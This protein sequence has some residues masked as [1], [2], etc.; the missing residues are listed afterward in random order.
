M[1]DK[2]IETTG[3]PT[4]YITCLGDLQVR[5]WDQPTVNIGGENYQTEEGEKGLSI[6]GQSDLVV[7]LPTA[8]NVT[9]VA[10]RG[11]LNVRQISGPLHVQEANGDAVVQ[12]CNSVGAGVVHGDF[13]VRDQSGS[14]SVEEVMGDLSLRGV[15]DV[16][17]G[18]VYGDCVVQ[19]AGGNVTIGECLGDVSL[20]SVGGDVQLN[21]VSGD[22]G[23]RSVGG[24]ANVTHTRG[25]IRLRGSLT[26]GKHR[27]KADGDVVIRW[28]IGAPINIE[29]RGSRVINRMSL[30]ESSEQGGLF[31]GR[32]GMGG[33][34][35]LV[36]ANGRIILKDLDAAEGW[37]ESAGLDLDFSDLGVHISAEINS[38]MSEIASRLEQKLGPQFA[39][40]MEKKAQEAAARA[41]RAAERA[42]RKAEKA[43]RRAQWQARRTGYRPPT[44]ARP[45]RKARQATEEEQLKIL[46]MVEQGVI[47]PDEANTLLQAIED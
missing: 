46:K 6:T 33:T 3:A 45:A 29:A 19:N 40:R 38:R 32:I 21:A 30:D 20:K 11:D 34:V 24:L 23:L 15:T 10:A 39:A 42:M 4:V 44:P 35:L 16:S 12:N 1:A 47:T 27:L 5:G 36:E 22:T 43:A 7:S 28:P 9:V 41:E 25:D 14:C 26:E 31:S 13:L 37:D 18:R 17:A 8:A 2:R